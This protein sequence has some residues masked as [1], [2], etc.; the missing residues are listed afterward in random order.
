VT[1]ISAARLR[2]QSRR[3]WLELDA[4]LDRFWRRHGEGLSTKELQTLETWLAFDDPEL[5]A[6]LHNPPAQWTNLA[7]K[8]TEK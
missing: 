8:I 4:L 5:W 2:W 1:A 3:G 6:T 7:K